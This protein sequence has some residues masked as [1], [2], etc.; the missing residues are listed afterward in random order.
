MCG[1]E[2]LVSLNS[3]ESVK[4]FYKLL[5]EREQLPVP[6][7]INV[8][9]KWPA[10]RNDHYCDQKVCR[11]A[12]LDLFPLYMP[13]DSG[14]DVQTPGVDISILEA[15]PTV[16]FVRGQPMSMP[17]TILGEFTQYIK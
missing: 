11:H 2:P 13:S 3:A 15:T 7:P 9:P 4:A 5:G 14:S 1:A 12:V 17:V 16:Q 8:S 10:A 6:R